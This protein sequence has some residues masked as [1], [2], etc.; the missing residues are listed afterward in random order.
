MAKRFLTALYAVFLCF[1]ILLMSACTTQ[2]ADPAITTKFTA[3]FTADY[4]DMTV[5]GSVTSGGFGA[6]SIS[7]T[8]PQTLSG[9]N[10]NYKNSEVQLSREQIVC[11]ADEAFIPQNGFPSMISAALNEIAYNR[12][13]FVSQ[14][15]SE[16]T[17]EF[18]I[19]IGGCTADFDKDG[20]IR[21][22]SV[23][24]AKLYAEFSNVKAIGT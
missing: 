23:P 4:N 6:L 15:E 24:S 9:L 19:S 2:E 10:I 7:I 16:L 12:M 21:K 8:Y 11:T 1:V 20:L 17:Y 5:K 14:N 18:K 22:I 13:N 3:D